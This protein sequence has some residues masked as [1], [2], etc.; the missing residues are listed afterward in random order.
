MA[1][2]IDREELRNK[3]AKGN[4][5]LIDTLPASAYARGHI[6]GAINLPSEEIVAC[7]PAQI[8]NTETEII[9]YCKNG[10]CQ[11]SGKAAT[12]LEQ[13]GYTQVRDYHAGQDDWTAAGLPLHR[14]SES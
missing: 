11:R 7:A 5:V 4:V 8:P 2:T 3:L 10:P 13:L 9:V 12:R 6:P 14:P 1:E